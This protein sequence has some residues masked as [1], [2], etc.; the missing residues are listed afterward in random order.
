MDAFWQNIMKLCQE[1]REASRQSKWMVVHA[2]ISAAHE[3]IMWCKK[4]QEQPQ[5]FNS[6]V[7]LRAAAEEKMRKP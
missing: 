2:R 6:I 1:A 3:S 4:Q 7:N 5:I